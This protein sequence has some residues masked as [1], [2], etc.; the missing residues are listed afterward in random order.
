M[1]TK[2]PILIGSFLAAVL[3]LCVAGTKLSRLTKT[4]TG[5]NN[6]LFY[7]VTNST[8]NGGRA[9]EATNLVTF[10]SGLP[11]WPI[12]TN[13]GSATN[14]IAIVSGTGTNT[15]LGNPTLI[16]HT[17]NKSL[18]HYEGAYIQPRWTNHG[19]RPTLVDS[20]DIN[21]FTLR[22]DGGQRILYYGGVTD[23]TKDYLRHETVMFG[24]NDGNAGSWKINFNDAAAWQFFENR[25]NNI[26][27]YNILS[28]VANT[29]DPLV[30]GDTNVNT[31]AQGKTASILGT[32]GVGIGGRLIVTN[33]ATVNG[34]STNN[35]D[36]YVRRIIDVRGTNNHPIAF[37]TAYSNLYPQV[38]FQKNDD[39]EAAPTKIVSGDQLGN[40]EFLG[41]GGSTY[42]SGFSIRPFALND[43]G[44]STAETLTIFRSG[45]N[46]ASARDVWGLSPY[47]WTNFVQSWFS[48][49]VNFS[50]GVSFPALTPN[51]VLALNAAGNATNTPLRLAQT[52]VGI[53]DGQVLA[54]NS[55][56]QAFTNSAA[57]GNGEVNSGA[58]LGGALALFAG[59]SGVN[60][61]FNSLSNSD[62]SILIS[63][64]ANTI[65]F[66]ATNIGTSKLTDGG[67]TLAKMANIATDSLIGRDT[68]GTGVPEVIGVG[69]GIEFTG[70]GAIQRSAL[71]GD[72]T[73]SAGSGAVT[74]PNNTVTYA[75]MQD[76]SST[77][78]VL[79]RT[80]AGSGDPQEA[81]I[82]TLLDWIYATRGGILFRDG[83]NWTNLAPG[84]AGQFLQTG[85][86]GAD[87]SWVTPGTLTDGNKT[88]I[89]VG[90]AGSQWLI[91]AGAVSNSKFRDS[92]GL[93]VV[94]RSANSAGSV[95]DMIAAADGQVVRRNGTTVGFGALDLTSANAIS[96]VIPR[97]N[98]PTAVPYED[99]NNVFTLQQTF[100]GP[101]ATTA[102][103]IVSTDID[104]SLA[105][106]RKKTL[107]AD[108]VFTF[109]NLADDRWLR[110]KITQN[111]TGGWTNAWPS[112]IVWIN[113][114]NQSSAPLVASGANAVT[115]MTFHRENGTVYGWQSGPDSI[116][117][118]DLANITGLTKGDLFV[119]SGTHLQRQLAG[120]DG[121]YLQ[122]SS[123]SS[124]GV[125][126][127]S[128][129]AG[130]VQFGTN[131]TTV[132]NQTNL[133]FWA[134]NGS[135]FATNNTSGN[136]VD[137]TIVGST[138]Q[139]VEATGVQI[140]TNQLI[141]INQDFNGSNGVTATA[142]A[143]NWDMSLNT[144]KPL[145]NFV[146]TNLT[147]TISN[148]VKSASLYS[149]FIGLGTVSSG[150]SNTV[151]VGAVSGVNIKWM[152]W[153]TNGN[154]DILVR[155]GYS[156][157]LQMF[158]DR[159]TNVHA[160][161]STDDPYNPLSIVTFS[162]FTAGISNLVASNAVVRA[163]ASSSNAT[164]GG[165]L[166]IST[167][168]VTNF[169]T[170]QFTNLASFTV[171]GNTL[172]NNGDQLIAEWTGGTQN[173]T[174][175][176]N[177]GYSGATTNAISVTLSNLACVYRGGVS[178]TRLSATSVYAVPWVTVPSQ[179]STVSYTNTAV[180]ITT[181]TG[182]NTPISLIVGQPNA[183]RVNSL[184][185]TLFKVR[186]E[187]GSK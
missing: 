19:V 170:A 133:T 38:V 58:N 139:P 104:W 13:A 149:A 105:N 130:I 10:L 53:S 81:G 147:F 179:A 144:F 40:I 172:T 87:V 61:Q 91:N 36:L 12:S 162:A 7:I 48:S 9:I 106:F 5:P 95:A 145:T 123:G 34:A 131:N 17:T 102:S 158:A 46:S 119:W 56:M 120:S 164:L 109:S 28:N 64:N 63:S 59:K 54:Y 71:T 49:N 155:N 142:L 116:A 62:S 78:R 121:Q 138:N 11:N 3:I 8:P 50:A 6:S 180:V 157:T 85:G 18:I 154:Y 93:S 21:I 166:Y 108:T 79:A 82:T 86:A 25:L 92:S 20:N 126:W 74:I 114:T 110:V 124:N 165:T 141:Y 156:Y 152:N 160:W 33:S 151:A 153:A 52:F 99:E 184:S 143:A 31:V 97:V 101:F 174:N 161:V 94:G 113:S 37:I 176:I 96:G 77:Q 51:Q 16:G 129:G 4:V 43:F 29:L 146:G 178:I 117:L 173:G 84:T 83:N 60:L 181:D 122:A 72:A 39:I 187:P 32:A 182:T 177:I 42:K 167:A 132:G 125:A 80:S 159:A 98:L 26:A 148:V 89:T 127:V 128:T 15:S 163:G 140:L 90:G 136:K 70:A 14:A 100:T 35:A 168:T 185:N 175:T 65:Q 118:T 66:S 76:I 47:N 23:P 2:R 112:G 27:G 135:V 107:T 1:N 41:Y 55:G 150:Y 137:V 30:L 103:N 68:A 67:V 134:V 69:G 171:P 24:L 111:G 75:K 57:S 169:N 44:N 88:D 45:N 183:N 22:T 115:Y 73:A 186:Y